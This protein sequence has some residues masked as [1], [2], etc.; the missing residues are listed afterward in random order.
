MK[1][2]E[3]KMSSFTRAQLHEYFD[4]RF[5]PEQVDKA[6]QILSENGAEIDPNTDEFSIEVTDELEKIFDAVGVAVDNQK[7]LGQS[8]ESTA[9]R[10]RPRTS[11][12]IALGEDYQ[13][14]YQLVPAQFQ[15]QLDKLPE[16]DRLSVLLAACEG[17][18]LAELQFLAKETF[19]Q[20]RLTQLRNQSD[21]GKLERSKTLS[22][23]R[24]NFADFDAKE[25]LEKLEAE[26]LLN[27]LLKQ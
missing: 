21:N 2:G 18:E 9:I 5:T 15:A 3:Q 1:T 13:K 6:L 20:A 23:S 4:T 24:D 10:N 26:Q 27:A 22:A 8:Q 25:F 7:K 12:A 11:G 17:I 19:E 16:R 14:L